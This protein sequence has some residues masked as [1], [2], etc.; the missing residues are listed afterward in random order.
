MDNTINDI[1][2]LNDRIK[3]TYTPTGEPG[4]TSPLDSMW[5]VKAE[6]KKLK[7]ESYSNDTEDMAYATLPDGSKIAK[8][9]NYIAGTDNEERL[10]QGQS[11]GEKWANGA[12]KFFAK[13][14]VAVL[15][16]TVGVVNDLIVGVKEGSL[17]AAYN[18]DLSK[19]MDDLNTK[20]DY[21][22]PNYYTEQEKEA[23]F[24]GSLGSAN[25][26][27]N[28]FLGGL[29]F[30]AGA[31]VSEGIWAAATGG[32]SLLAKGAMGGLSRLGAKALTKAELKVAGMAGKK[33]ATEP[34]RI[35]A[36]AL[37]AEAKVANIV[38]E[39]G[40]LNSAAISG[41]RAVGAVKALNTLRFTTT[42]A[43]F[44][45]AMEARH[46]MSGAES[47]W[48]SKFESENGRQPNLTEYTEF[49]DRLTDSG[50]AVFAANMVL[51]GS[52]NMVTFGKLAMGRSISAEVPNSWFSK[53]IL[54]VGFKEGATKGSLEAIKATGKQKVVSRLYQA[55]QSA[56]AEGL[57]E[58]GGQAV[59]SKTAENYMLN[60][61][62]KKGLETSYGMQNAFYDAL[63]TTY[64]TKQGFKEV[65]LGMLIGVFG[66]GVSGALSGGGI[67]NEAGQQRKNIEASVDLVNKFHSG[68][69]VDAY[70]ANAKIY[71]A[72]EK[73]ERA[74]RKGDLVG[75]VQA[76]REAM[77]STLESY[78]NLGG[79]E[80]AIEQHNAAM[81]AVPN[82][83]LAEELGI[84]VEEAAKWKTQRISEYKELA[85]EYELYSQYSES[86]LGDVAIKGVSTEDR[87]TLGKAITFNMVMGKTALKD[88]QNITDTM[89][90]FVAAELTGADAVNQA[91]DTNFVLN[92]VSEEKT[93]EYTV[94]K[95]KGLLLEARQKAL[96][97]KIVDIQ[98]LPNREDNV[99]RTTR[100]TNV[101]K[102][103]LEV[104]QEIEEVK[105]QKEA[106]AAAI[107]VE[108]TSNKTVTTQM[109]DDQA[110]NTIK[111]K[112]SL[113]A[114]KNKNP[115]NHAIV[116]K[117]MQEQMRAI[118]NAKGFDATTKAILDPNTRYTLM[119]GWLASIIKGRGGKESDA[120]FF[121]ESLANYKASLE[122]MNV[123]QAQNE[124][125][126]MFSIFKSGEKLPIEY[127]TKL[128]DLQKSKAELT[129]YQ[130]EML[131]ANKEV[132]EEVAVD[133]LAMPTVDEKVTALEKERD[134]KIATIQGN[135]IKA[136]ELKPG[137]KFEYQG[138]EYTVKDINENI[139]KTIH[140]I[141]TEE[142]R[143]I[144]NPA[145]F[146][147]GAYN[148]WELGS[149]TSTS[150]DQVEVDR[151]SKLSGWLASYE[152]AKIAKTE[153][154]DL[155]KMSREEYVEYAIKNNL[156][157]DDSQL[158][159]TPEQR[160]AT[161]VE[162]VLAMYKASKSKIEIA[163][164]KAFASFSYSMMKLAEKTQSDRFLFPDVRVLSGTKDS[165]S[166]LF[167]SINNGTNSAVGDT[168][169]SYISFSDLNKLSPDSFK[170]FLKTLQERGYNGG[171]KIFQDLSEQGTKLN[172]Q[173]VMHGFSETDAQLAL[174]VAKE[175]FKDNIAESSLGKDEIVN[176]VSKSYSQIL[177]ERIKKT[178]QDNLSTQSS[179]VDNTK[180]VS[181]IEEEYRKKIEALRPPETKLSQLKALQNK[182]SDI[183]NTNKYVL[184]YFG[185]DVETRQEPT[186]SEIEE[187]QALQDQ[188]VLGQE[189][190]ILYN[191]A[192]NF[193][194]EIA[195][196][197]KEQIKRYQEL[198]QKLNDWKTLDGT[199]VEGQDSSIADL[200]KIIQALKQD[201][202]QDDTKTNFTEEEYDILVKE[203]S[204]EWGSSPSTIKTP[205]N[206]LANTYKDKDG[207]PQI[208]ISF[209][210]IEA[211]STMFPG[212]EFGIYE[213]D[214]IVPYEEEKH[215][216]ISKKE[217]TKFVITQG[218][219]YVVVTIGKNSRLIIPKE[220]MDAMDS[221]LSILSIG[222]KN[223]NMVFEEKPD[224]TLQMLESDFSFTDTEGK[225]TLVAVDKLNS[226][227]KGDTVEMKI[228]R[229]DTY[230]AGLL[231]EYYKEARKNPE[232]ALEKLENSLSIYIYAEGS[233]ELLG[234][235]SAIDGVQSLN[236]EQN[237]AIRKEATKRLLESNER[238]VNTGQKATVQ[239]VLLGS[240]NIE[241]QMTEN[242]PQVSTVP[243]T[244]E[245]LQ[246]V[247]GVGYMQGEKVTTT[248]TIGDVNYTYVKALSRNRKSEKVPFV[249]VEYQ[250]KNIAFPIKMT[251]TE[252]SKLSEL[253]DIM[254]SNLPMDQKALRVIE[255]MQKTGID[256]KQFPIDFS[257][258]SWQKSIE[259]EQ[260]ANKLDR[261]ESFITADQLVSK[262]F[263]ID[264]LLTEAEI[265][266]D[267]SNKPFRAGKMTLKLQDVEFSAP[268]EAKSESV[269][270]SS[271][272]E[273]DLSDEAIAIYK[274]FNKVFYTI[275]DT[276]FVEAF[277]DR[278]VINKPKDFLEV[279]SNSRILKEGLAGKVPLKVTR[280]IGKE[281]I[282]KIKGQIARLDKLKAKQK[283]ISL[284]GKL[285]NQADAAKKCA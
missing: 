104:E 145:V 16:G 246:N 12:E 203:E 173:V 204:Q 242:G 146:G 59:A 243:F 277:D 50:N 28:D 196:I 175:F 236:V 283:E 238:Y 42:S 147:V 169:K 216:T 231:K 206:V 213:G 21:K 148:T 155:S 244:K 82:D 261:Q 191:D 250:G 97:Q 179:Q 103:L 100:L 235:L 109:L 99:D 78:S 275:E 153:G 4:R 217:G 14:A 150:S 20:L 113:N 276:A 215:R 53:N 164:E 255:L 64:G 110:E 139:G 200:L 118:R 268:Y 39:G 75:Q 41:N 17:S 48:L 34:F 129:I 178:I 135:K 60:G 55:G 47:T 229:E 237:K 159:A 51:V 270:T 186:Q 13:T 149:A 180:E 282:A 247:K 221:S 2:Y 259:M 212:S 66:G 195:G 61:Y 30:T 62:D 161:T 127:L 5:D 133:S 105:L 137:D 174:D 11:T 95:K 271:E 88:S 3:S 74:N 167:F 239:A 273:H 214:T 253:E 151:R 170:D 285:K 6:P 94:L 67:F 102:E 211:F 265:A 240:P 202:A 207:I 252:D 199:V 23:G 171:V 49:K 198:N 201:V 22:L 24:V 81:E 54:G 69:L 272:I 228:D 77:L 93:A 52:S 115:H 57:W 134:E 160:T 210:S 87:N 163:V 209:L 70:K 43:G 227:E 131:D 101:S 264:S 241:A 29:S 251:I 91:I 223:N 284:Q 258:T 126:E 140:S 27:A 218:D 19:W 144:T 185:N 116:E 281:R 182:L 25:F 188:I 220:S 158:R 40:A 226:M 248:S 112:A 84:T 35:T 278:P 192:D 257:N 183:L 123:V 8:F 108:N 181:K 45:S 225:D 83:K 184:E 187:Y 117:L 143:S 72:V 73:S 205:D 245:A 86:L 114:L 89:K 193:T 121:A 157:I 130:Q 165:N 119:N 219:N 162:E 230:N 233:S 68:N 122:G 38:A 254:S 31:I 44:E 10:A 63:S 152:L 138:K 98:A 177:S 176:G 124:D 76:D 36:K 120:E 111:L 58:E 260:L 172:D 96:L 106:A 56:V 280:L 267:V 79:V 274:E 90:R 234:N 9:E 26:W 7:F 190:N 141:E 37:S 168:Y 46:Y 107:N 132:I 156:A 263:D 125:N 222:V 80:F 224:G 18:S 128:R 71:Q 85:S 154:V 279:Q 208:S 232:T 136:T 166:W 256:P 194:K 1:T 262:D 189:Q 142:G 197:N 249:I 32:T 33:I 65:G 266:V 269:D 92:Q 15:G